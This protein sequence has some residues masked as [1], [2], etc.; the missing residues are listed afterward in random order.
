MN[1]SFPGIASPA[2]LSP[3]ASGMSAVVEA[4]L[5][6]EKEQG[7][8]PEDP[9]E[10]RAQHVFGVPPEARWDH[11]KHQAKQPPSLRG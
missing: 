8:D 9:D 4:G 11:L 10:Y 6:G 7:A 2:F 3:S 5:A 1:A